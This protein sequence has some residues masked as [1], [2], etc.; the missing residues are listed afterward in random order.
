MRRNFIRGLLCFVLSAWCTG[1]FGQRT[2]DADDSERSASAR[3]TNFHKFRYFYKKKKKY[4]DYYQ[5]IDTSAVYLVKDNDDSG[6]IRFFSNG[7]FYK[8]FEY[9]YP[10]AREEFN[11]LDYG[12]WGMFKVSRNG[13]VLEWKEHTS[14]PPN[15]MYYYGEIFENKIIFRKLK[16]GRFLLNAEDHVNAQFDKVKLTS[17]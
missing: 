6:F 5:L 12:K 11:K 2:R 10:I 7:L 9:R 15:F 4:A 13:I 14:F 16:F 8:S 1:A 3:P 17:N